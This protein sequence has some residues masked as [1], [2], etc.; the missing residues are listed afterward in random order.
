MQENSTYRTEQSKDIGLTSSYLNSPEFGRP[1]KE[2]MDD[3]TYKVGQEIDTEL[4]PA[5]SDVTRGLAYGLANRLNEYSAEQ[6][7]PG[8]QEVLDIFDR[9]RMPQEIIGKKGNIAMIARDA[10][11]GYGKDVRNKPIRIIDRIDAWDIVKG[12]RPEDETPLVVPE[13]RSYL[14]ETVQSTLTETLS[15][16]KDKLSADEYDGLSTKIMDRSEEIA[17]RTEDYLPTPQSRIKEVIKSTDGIRNYEDAKSRVESQIIYDAFKAAGWDM[18]KA[19]KYLKDDKR[20][21]QSRIEKL[22]MEVTLKRAEKEEKEM[23][24]RMQAGMKRG[25]EKQDAEDKEPAEVCELE[26]FR[27]LRQEQLQKLYDQK[28]EMERKR[29]RRTQKGLR[30]AA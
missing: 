10:F 20:T 23:E 30:L 9:T 16:Y 12:A 19:V 2:L 29:K 6:A 18:N 13:P 28:G 17:R 4:S 1:T 7:Y 8:R 21:L 24:Q 27:Q 3:L 14:T 25:G 5:F 15:G 22:G 26:R 11:D